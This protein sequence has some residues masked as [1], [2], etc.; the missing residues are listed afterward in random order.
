M[1]TIEQRTG[2]REGWSVRWR[3]IDGRQRRHKCPDKRAAIRIAAEVEASAARGVDWQPPRDRQG[4]TRIE[5]V[6]AAY[7][8]HRSI[9]VAKDTL[10][11]DGNHLELVGRFLTLRNVT[12]LRELSRPLLD[13]LLAWLLRPKG[14]MHGHQRAPQTANKVA[15]AALM[16]WRWAE[17]RYPDAPRAPHE[18]DLAPAVRAQVVAPTWAEM[19]ACVLAARGWMRQLATWLRYTGLR[20]G[21]S[22]LLE[23]RDIDMDRGLLTIRAELDK[24]RVGRTIPLHPALLDAIATWGKREGFVIPCGRMQTREVRGR[25]LARAWARAG[26]REVVWRQRPDHAFRKGFKTGLRALGADVDAADF[27][28]GHQLGAGSRGRYIDGAHLPLAATLSMVPVI[29]GGA[30]ASNVVSLEARR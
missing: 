12:L 6:T 29:G 21:E 4:P 19:D 5:D 30:A 16:L 26:V 27:L 14:G 17:D 1:A 2:D 22:M 25:D 13:D 18:L 20:V 15:S 24:N 23:W 8:A 10:R 7:L 3:A 9:R 28:Q 11:V